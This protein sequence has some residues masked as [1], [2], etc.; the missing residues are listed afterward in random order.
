MA[1]QLQHASVA[2]MRVS[3]CPCHAHA[4]FR[5]STV[6]SGK[7]CER[8]RRPCAPLQVR[9]KNE[10]LGTCVRVEPQV[11]ALFAQPVPVYT[12]ARA[13][14]CSH[15]ACQDHDSERLY[16]AC[17]KPVRRAQ[18]KAY[19]PPHSHATCKSTEWPPATGRGRARV[20]VCPCPPSPPRPIS[21]S[22]FVIAHQAY[23]DDS[24]CIC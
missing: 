6:V 9:R 1:F 24:Y 4:Q 15:T 5:G 23:G 18:T 11:N 22:I 10:G 8:A 7:P 16:K 2:R 17:Y 12:R 19:A 13:R 14:A 20:D 3:W 21:I